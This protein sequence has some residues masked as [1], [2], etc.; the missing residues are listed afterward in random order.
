MCVG[1]HGGI[2][3]EQ[4]QIQIGNIGLSPKDQTPDIHHYHTGKVKEIKFESTP[5]VFYGPTQ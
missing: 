2:A 3:K 5:C 4:T 1:I